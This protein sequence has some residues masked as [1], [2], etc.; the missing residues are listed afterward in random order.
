MLNKYVKLDGG[1]VVRILDK[2]LSNGYDKYL[3]EI[4]GGIND[5]EVG[6]FILILPEDIR[7]LA[8]EWVK[9]HLKKVR[10]ELNKK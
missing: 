1:R 9:N 6:G 5:E 10:D 3:C 7:G 2:V 8:E 4:V